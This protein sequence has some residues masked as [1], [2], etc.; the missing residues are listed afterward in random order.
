MLSFNI[1]S[2]NKKI[3]ELELLLHD[4]SNKD[5]NFKVICLQEIWG[6]PDE[7]SIKLNNY[8]NPLIQIRDSGI[9]GGGLALYIRDNLSFEHNKEFS[10]ID[11]EGRFESLFVKIFL[12]DKDFVIVGNFYRIPNTN[13][14]HF[15]D[16]LSNTLNALERETAYRNAKEIIL[17]GDFNVNFLN[18]NQHNQTNEMLNLFVAHSFLPLLTLPSRIT[19]NT[20]NLLD[21]IFTNKKQ[22]F[23]ESGLL[24]ST[25]SDHLPTCYFN[26]TTS[27]RKERKK[28]FYHDMSTKNK[29]KF[30]D[31][32]K[33]KDWSNIITENNP[34]L[35]FENFKNE[36]N[37]SYLSCFPLKEKKSNIQNRPSK[38]W[39]TPELI[40]LRKKNE[41]LLSKKLKTRSLD[42]T[43][44]FNISNKAYSK[45]KRNE[46]R[47]YFKKK[48][49]DYANDM[50]KTWETI[51]SLVKRKRSKSDIPS[52]F[53]DDNRTYS[54]F[55][56]IA[57]GFNDF[58][59][60]IGQKLANEIPQTGKSFTDFMGEKMHQNFV[61]DCI[62][63]NNI[64]TTLSKL[65]PKYSSGRDK[66]STVLLKEIMPVIIKPVTYLFNLS[67]K[68]G[69]IPPDYKCAKII[70]IYK[71]GP[72]DRFDNYRPISILPAFSKLLE[73]LVSIQLMKYL[74]RYNILHEN[75]FGFRKGRDTKQPLIQLLQKIYDGLNKDQSEVTLCVFL[76]LKKAFD[77]CDFSILL[78]KL[79]HY[80]I[81][82]T[83]QTWFKNYLTGR[84][85]YVHINGI[86][87]NENN[88]QF[89]VPQ[90]SVMGPILFLLYINDMPNAT[91][92]FSSLFADDTMFTC[93][94]SNLDLL[95]SFS[96]KELEKCKIWFQTNKLSL[97]VSKTKFMIFRSNKMPTIQENFKLFIGDSEIERIGSGLKT[98]C[99]KF[100]GV[101]LDETLSWNFHINHVNSKLAS[102]NY[103][104][105]QVKNILPKNILKTIYAAM[106]KPHIEYS[107]VTW[108]LSKNK[109]INKVIKNQKKS[110][111]MIENAN[112][113]S[114]TD[115]LFSKLGILKFEDILTT[116]VCE[117]VAKFFK[118]ELPKSFDNIFK[119]LRTN[120][121]ANLLINIPKTKQLEN[122]PAV[123]FPKIW[124]SQKKDVRLPQSLKTMKKKLKN[125]ALSRYKTFKCEK[126]KCYSCKK[127]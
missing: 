92:F 9:R 116:N 50:K 46:K 68:T 25:I 15:N 54:N 110:I 22:N 29:A 64:L 125:L 21:M 121:A 127:H 112:Y 119:S 104:L 98:Q 33:S 43:N 106:F 79:D 81:R 11:N 53:K 74:N 10:H 97:N 61:F 52:I 100:V 77:T 67:L 96:N 17:C 39:F 107:I 118:K 108:G 34:N 124:N 12:N 105:N 56:D 91:S 114:H 55:F 78:G 109:G 86:D 73:K 95:K 70:P 45:A 27:K 20:A 26:L 16:Y 5:F 18:C 99:F 31:N 48:F 82:G 94:G 49:E 83:A 41:K 120:R 14:K 122:F 24:M 23:Y 36:L 58:F 51:N 113:N 30:T 102:A 62:T 32:L 84:K 76:D 6:V 80:G 101:Y 85:Q 59:C 69:Y 28:E 71:S 38:P 93:S 13:I 123:A 72:M 7:N 4:T 60:N 57:E 89:G 115:P 87:S 75:Q 126:S 63:E 3:D 40:G 35:A 1:R 2:I 65:K 42:A 90:G 44:K 19:E 103:A 37:Q 66:I 88:I 8:H 111:R 117:F 47:K